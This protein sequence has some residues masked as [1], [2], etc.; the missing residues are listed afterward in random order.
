MLP[1]APITWEASA[2]AARPRVGDTRSPTW[3]HEYKVGTTLKDGSGRYEFGHRRWWRADPISAQLVEVSLG[4]GGHGIRPFKSNAHAARH[5]SCRLS[6]AWSR[7]PRLTIQRLGRRGVLQLHNDLEEPAIA[8]LPAA[9]VVGAPR[10]ERRR[11]QER[12]DLIDV[13]ND[14]CIVRKQHLEITLVRQIRAR[15]LSIAMADFSNNAAMPSSTAAWN[16]F[17]C[18]NS[19]IASSLVTTAPL[20]AAHQV[21]VCD[22]SALSSNPRAA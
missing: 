13:R 17:P 18:R 19:S 16:G 1:C 12:S 11:Q 22:H 6:H 9:L 3:G 15:Q 2:S 8:L 10:P 5:H 4:N 21:R 7:L 20:Q 14:L